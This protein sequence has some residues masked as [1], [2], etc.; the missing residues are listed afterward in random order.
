VESLDLFK[1]HKLGPGDILKISD[2]QRQRIYNAFETKMKVLEKRTYRDASRGLTYTCYLADAPD[3]I[4]HMVVVKEVGDQFETFVYYKELEG[5]ACDFE[6]L[7]DETK[8]DLVSISPPIEVEERKSLKETTP[9]EV[10]FKKK[11]FGTLFGVRMDSHKGGDEELKTIGEYFS[12]D[13]CENP[14]CF[15]EWTGNFSEG[16]IEIWYGSQVEKHEISLDDVSG[17]ILSRNNGILG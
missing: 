5:P 8:E 3:E 2:L 9:I 10:T 16:F 4:T 7:F 6:G 12:E 17:T 11:S 15:I 1:N 14:H 13:P